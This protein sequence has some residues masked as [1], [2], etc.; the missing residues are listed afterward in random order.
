MGAATV[1]GGYL[2]RVLLNTVFHL[3]PQVQ[4]AIF[5][6]ASRMAAFVG[7]DEGCN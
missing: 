6:K 1:H 7:T 3:N 2:C 5:G 4:T